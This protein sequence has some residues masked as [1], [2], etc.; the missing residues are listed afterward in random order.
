[1]NCF[2]RFT[3]VASV[4][5]LLF[6]SFNGVVNA[7]DTNKDEPLCYFQTASGTK[8]NLASL[9]G[10]SAVKNNALILI[11]PLLNAK[12]VLAIENVKILSDR[13]GKKPVYYL[14]G[15]IKNN[16]DTSQSYIS[17][18]YSLYETIHG[19]LKIY[20]SHDVY[21]D[22]KVLQPGETTTFVSALIDP[23][24]TTYLESKFDRAPELVMIDSLDSVESGLN[25]FNICYVAGRSD[26]Q[27]CQRLNPSSIREIGYEHLHL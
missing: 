4:W 17:V 12:S 9:C 26:F 20:Y 7:Q 14:G 19:D 24:E 10:N 5:V 3:G 21:V 11:T 2:K 16:G 8:V 22:N 6:L 13:S 23:G 15:V 18:K 27:L 1:M 25:I